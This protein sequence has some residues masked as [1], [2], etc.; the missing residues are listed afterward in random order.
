MGAHRLDQ[1]APDLVE[2]VQ[3]D[4]G[5]WKTIA[6]SL[7]LIARSSRFGQRHQ[8]VAVEHDPAGDRARPGGA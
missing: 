5:S 1:L 6:I 3:R 4:S 2:R 8:V 7:P